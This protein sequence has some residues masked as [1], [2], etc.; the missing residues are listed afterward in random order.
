[1][2][3]KNMDLR[4][5]TFKN[6]RT[7]EL[8]TV[9]DAFENIAI[10]ENKEKIDVR[11]LTNNE[12]FTEQI[13]PKNFFSNQS[14][15]NILADKIKNIPQSQIR[16]DDGP[17]QRVDV[18]P[19]YNN[20]DFGPIDNESAIIVSTEDD[21]RAELARKYGASIDNSSVAR[22]NEA[23]AKLL[24]EDSEDLPIIQNPPVYSNIS[25]EE[26]VQ[27]IEI[28]R[29]EPN[30]IK[31]N[32]KVQQIQQEVEDPIITMFRKTKRNV[33][34]N[35]SVDISDKIPRLDFIEMMEDSYEISMIDFLSEEFT[36]KIIQNPSI[37]KDKIKSRITELVYGKTETP[38]N[39][40]ITDSVTQTSEVKVEKTKTVRKPRAKKESTENDR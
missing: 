16:D 26:P 24:G 13:D 21:E 2:K 22:Q 8:V 3:Q 32:Q 1:M 37:I 28:N 19:G 6:N 11:R 35:I 17:V 33:D 18:T 36:N 27:R 4:N 5:K 39:P 38:V 30:D 25:V 7:G 12:F 34:F 10:L 15:Y 29:E 40:Q 14:A 31:I 23:F 9:I 20:S